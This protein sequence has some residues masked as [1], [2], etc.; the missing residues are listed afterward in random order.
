MIMAGIVFNQEK[1]EIFEEV[2]KIR[3][4]DKFPE[5]FKGIYDNF[6]GYG[7]IANRILE[8]DRYYEMLFW[9][10]GEI[11]KS[12]ILDIDIFF[13]HLEAIMNQHEAKAKEK[14][15]DFNKIIEDNYLPTCLT[16]R[17]V[18]ETLIYKIY[19]IVRDHRKYQSGTGNPNDY[20]KFNRD[21]VYSNKRVVDLE[22]ETKNLL[23]LKLGE[24]NQLDEIVWQK[25]MDIVTSIKNSFVIIF[26]MGARDF[27]FK[28]LQKTSNTEQYH[29]YWND[30]RA[31]LKF[32]VKLDADITI[33]E[34]KDD[35]FA[36]PVSY[37]I[38]RKHGPVKLAEDESLKKWNVLKKMMGI[39]PEEKV[40]PV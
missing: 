4:A 25:T 40:S 17:K 15:I 20:F 31:A 22:Q 21:I 1:P 10:Q 34:I 18:F 3:I 24:F 39:T 2:T 9:N 6:D 12:D 36:M 7:S 27:Y 33:A 19:K 30:I 16:K 26:E 23:E 28:I 14:G 13:T 29:L 37:H 8:Y 35:Q 5:L 32:A 11:K 38:N